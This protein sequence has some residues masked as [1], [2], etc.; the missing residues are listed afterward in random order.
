MT[1]E[2]PAGAG[3]AMPEE[4]ARWVYEAPI[5]TLRGEDHSG[6]FCAGLATF[7]GRT[8]AH[9]AAYKKA[10]KDGRSSY[11][12]KYKLYT[13]KQF[14]GGYCAGYVRWGSGEGTT[15]YRSSPDAMDQEYS[16][17]S[18]QFE[19]G[20]EIGWYYELFSGL[21]ASPVVRLGGGKWKWDDADGNERSSNVADMGLGGDLDFVPSWLYGVGI[22]LG[23]FYNAFGDGIGIRGGFDYTFPALEDMSLSIGMISDLRQQGYSADDFK[24]KSDVAG[25]MFRGNWQW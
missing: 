5:H 14:S 19:L 1:L 16:G 7:A 18:S 25:L 24:G 6:E 10:M 23:L 22:H 2:A 3:A 12:Y 21:H 15:K 8:N 4:R 11:S 9:N 17:A 20:L 13:A